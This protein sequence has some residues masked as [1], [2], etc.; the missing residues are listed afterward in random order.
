MRVKKEY[1]HLEIT[2]TWNG[3]TQKHVLGDLTKD[4]L[5]DL[6]YKGIDI[7]RWIEPEQKKYK[8]IKHGRK[9]TIQ[10]DVDE[11]EGIDE[12]LHV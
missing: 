4:E 12:N 8:A 10:G 5:E 6:T 3:L 11:Q 9:P 2:L 1:E 7:S